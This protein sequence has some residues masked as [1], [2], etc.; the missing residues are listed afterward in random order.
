MA[1]RMLPFPS[2][3]PQALPEGDIEWH[4]ALGPDE[5]PE[6]RVKTV[7]VGRRSLAMT[8][9]EGCYGALD[10][11]RPHQGGP[12]GEGT[13]EKGWPRC[14]WHGYDY[15]PCAGAPPPG[16]NDAPASYRTQ[17]RADGVYVASQRT[18]S[19]PAPCQ[20]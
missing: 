9:Y 4:R 20:T 13:I 1:I 6:G 5:L 10:N 7:T 15:S 19:T 16:F 18:R 2:L 17:V 3:E 11:R 8:H 12:L 14:P